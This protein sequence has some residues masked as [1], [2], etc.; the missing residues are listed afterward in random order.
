ML[1]LTGEIWYSRVS[2]NLRSTS[3]SSTKPLPPCV[4]R[5]VLAAAQLAS[6]ARCLAMFASAPHGSPRSEEHTSELQSRQY[7]VRRLLLET[8]RDSVLCSVSVCQCYHAR[9]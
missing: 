7:L 6:E 4:S 5:A 8:K 1:L 9:Y 3:Y 2:R